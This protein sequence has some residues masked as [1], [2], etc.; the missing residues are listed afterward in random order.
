MILVRLAP[1]KA[2][3]GKLKKA[4]DAG[5]TFAIEWHPHIASSTGEP[6]SEQPLSSVRELKPCQAPLQLK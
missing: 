3:D 1:V 5:Y 2:G 4:K 6:Y